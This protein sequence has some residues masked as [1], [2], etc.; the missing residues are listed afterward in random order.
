VKVLLLYNGAFVFG[1][2]ETLLCRMS[3]WFIRNGWDVDVIVQRS[4]LLEGH[5][6]PE[7]RV[8]E[9]GVPLSDLFD[10][11][12]LRAFLET[13][14]IEGVDVIFA[15]CQM[16]MVVGAFAR[17]FVRNERCVSFA[18]NFVPRYFEQFEGRNFHPYAL[19]FRY[20]LKWAY[21]KET[22]L[23][24]CSNYIGQ[25]RD[26]LGDEESATFWPLPVSAAPYL[27]RARRPRM[28]RIVSV[29]RLEPMKE[30]NL[31]MPRIIRELAD[32]G[33][34][35]EWHVYG[36]G[37]YEN[38]MQAAISR[39]DVGKSVFLH[40]ALDYSR[41]PEVFDDAYV[42][43][44]MGTSLIEAAMSGVPNLMAYPYDREGLTHG[45]LHKLDFE[46]LDKPNPR[47]SV[48]DELIRILRL[49]PDEYARESRMT[50]EYAMRFSE[51]AVMEIFRN[52]PAPVKMSAIHRRALFAMGRFYVWL[53]NYPFKWIK[54]A[55]C[56]FRRQT[57]SLVESAK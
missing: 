55:G 41:L 49:S 35:V 18:A 32:Q 1:G 19:I 23:A 38:E 39:Y 2:I 29:G 8:F 28:G 10:P 11:S 17:H 51:D 9:T 3:R 12:Q 56:L 20:A 34:P 47:L 52:L 21:R 33:L 4:Q 40:G 27:G 57:D 31:Y 15:Y 14:R 22:R 7:A 13:R 37:E 16:T 24:M 43:V 44:G 48:L 30:Y 25:L 46:D 5:V 53:K 26:Y 54:G 36:K 42:F 6:A 50:Q 45:P